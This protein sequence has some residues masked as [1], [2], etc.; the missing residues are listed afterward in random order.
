MYLLLFACCFAVVAILFLACC[1]ALLVFAS[2]SNFIAAFLN[3]AIF[4]LLFLLCS[5]CLA[6]L[7]NLFP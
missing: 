5:F 2:G 6:L 1:F 7:G 3:F 4:A